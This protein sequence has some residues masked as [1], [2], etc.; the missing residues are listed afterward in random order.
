MAV[1]RGWAVAGAV[2]ALMGV[3]MGAFGAHALADLPTARLANWETAARY[4]MYH[5]FGLLAVAVAVARSPVS[6][7]RHAGAAFVLGTVLFSGSLYAIALT[8]IRVLGMVA[9]VGGASFMA[10]WAL[11]AWAAWR[12]R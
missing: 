8:G 5:A 1:A 7:A 12:D 4:Q 3:G 2:A 9:P 6:V 10:G 11:L